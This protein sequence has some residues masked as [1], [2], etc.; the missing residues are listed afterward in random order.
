MTATL[1]ALD[2]FPHKEENKSNEVEASFSAVQEDEDNTKDVPLIQAP[3]KESIVIYGPVFSDPFYQLTLPSFVG[4]A[5]EPKKRKASRVSSRKSPTRPTYADY[6]DKYNQVAQ[7][8]M[9]LDNWIDVLSD[10]APVVAKPRKVRRKSSHRSKNSNSIEQ[11]DTV[12]IKSE[13]SPI[14]TFIQEDEVSDARTII[15]SSTQSSDDK[16]DKNIQ[17]SIDKPLGF[18]REIAPILLTA[19]QNKK[20]SAPK[21]TVVKKVE[22]S[23][24]S[25]IPT[26]ERKVITHKKIAQDKKD[27]YIFTYTPNIDTNTPL[28]AKLSARFSNT[29]VINDRSSASTIRRE[30]LDKMRR[31]NNNLSEKKE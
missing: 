20:A 5:E 26:K 22:K 18:E 23:N 1:I 13:D 2:F 4:V 6:V 25:D 9:N 21:K 7:G 12:E 3:N 17:D 28:Q 15:Q 14:S 27:N 8:Q 10:D 30:L 29:N 11:S 31:Q 16:L 19:E 24:L